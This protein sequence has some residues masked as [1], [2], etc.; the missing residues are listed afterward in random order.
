MTKEEKYKCKDDIRKAKRWYKQ[1]GRNSGAV[2]FV[3]TKY[4]V[5]ST[6]EIAVRYLMTKGFYF[7]LGYGTSKSFR[8]CYVS[9]N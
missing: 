2:A 1:F 7:N 5:V 9:I 4:N 8:T 6:L 3:Q